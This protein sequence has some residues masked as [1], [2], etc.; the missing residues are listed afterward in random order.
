MDIDIMLNHLSRW[1]EMLLRLLLAAAA[2]GLIGWERE[3]KGQSAG[4]RTHTMV[5]FGAALFT[6]AALDMAVPGTTENPSGD[7]IRVITGVAQGIG[8]I[9]AG[10]IFREKS[11]IKGLTTA[12]TVWVMG[13]LGVAWGIGAYALAIMATIIAYF[14]LRPLRKFE[15][16]KLRDVNGDG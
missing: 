1:G 10:M 7:A 6:L 3:V 8:F 12:A 2:G 5:A 15:K 16:K 11:K 4:L 9:G 14:V 13:A